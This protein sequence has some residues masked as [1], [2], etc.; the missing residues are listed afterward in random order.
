M[1][2]SLAECALLNTGYDMGL[3][4]Q[5]F[6]ATQVLQINLTEAGVALLQKVLYESTYTVRLRNDRMTTLKIRINPVTE[7]LISAEVIK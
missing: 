7:E 3:V 1:P 4:K 5:F 6:T 2:R